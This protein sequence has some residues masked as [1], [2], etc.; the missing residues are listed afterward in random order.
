MSFK[1]YLALADIEQSPIDDIV[2]DQIVA[3]LIIKNSLNDRVR[4]QLLVEIFSV[5]N[6]GGFPLIPDFF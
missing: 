1:E 4:E 3:R 5:N 2:R 6:N